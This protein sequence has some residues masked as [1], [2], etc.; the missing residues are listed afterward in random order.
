MK[1]CLLWLFFILIVSGAGIAAYEPI[2]SFKRDKPIEKEVSISLYKVGSYTSK[3]YNESSAEV[4]VSIE[5][6]GSTTRSVVWDTTF[7][8]MLLRK[9]P[10]IKK[11]M[12]KKIIVPDVREKK[13]HLEMNYLLT[14][15]SKGSALRIQGRNTVVNV[16]DTIAIK[17]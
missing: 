5:K 14:Y 1:R 13:E 11:A 4:Y 9:Y 7:D 12:S 2:T 16:K 10:S 6:V 15:N 8:A 17:L 3:A